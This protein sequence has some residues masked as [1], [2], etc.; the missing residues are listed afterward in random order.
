M[1]ALGLVKSQIGLSQVKLLKPKVILG[2]A[3][4]ALLAGCGGSSPVKKQEQPSLASMPSWLI[5]T[6][7]ESGY[8]YGTGS[9]E[10]YAGDQAGAAARAK[11]M[12][13]LELIKQIEVNISG[14]TEQEI[15]D[16]YKDNK[17]ELTERIRQS[18]K[19][20]VSS[21]ELSH[22]YDVD[23]YFDEKNKQVSVLVRLDSNKEL[24][25]LKSQIDVIDQRFSEIRQE[26]ADDKLR[27][28]ELLRLVAS[29]LLLS[30]QRAT[31]Q[32]RVNALNPSRNH[33]DVLNPEYREFMKKAYSRMALITVKVSSLSNNQSASL[34]AGLI[35]ELNKKGITVSQG[36]DADIQIEIDLSVN[37]VSR[38]D[39]EFAITEGN[40]YLKTPDGRI[41]KTVQAKA[42]GASVDKKVAISRSIS[43]LS[44]QLG[45][46]LVKAL[47]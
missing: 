38:G 47:F 15:I 41:I 29:G 22:V 20:K 3:I 30:E 5:Q 45:K 6:P 10:V 33:V 2:V 26:F 39:T 17:S 4:L 27:G 14:E 34:T 11:D 13:R 21:F 1:I 40:V 36:S 35:A 12:A 31:I 24:H 18:V 37:S 32:S 25:S 44:E 28:I 42:K 46:E 43:K 8:L 9:A 16:T 7:V 19:S 23:S